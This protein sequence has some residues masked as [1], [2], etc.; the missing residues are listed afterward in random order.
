MFTLAVIAALERDFMVTP[1]IPGYTL[2]RKIAEG[3]SAEIYKALR[4][5]YGEECALKILHAR[6]T[7][8]RAKVKAFEAEVDILSRLEHPNVVV[9]GRSVE[10]ASRPCLE[11]EL[12]DTQHLK[13]LMAASQREGELLPLERALPILEQLARALS[14]LHDQGWLHRDIKPENVLV[15]EDDHVKL[16]DFS[17]ALPLHRSFWSRLFG[18]TELSEGTP[19]YL[20][21]EQI[22]REP[23]D[24]RS[25]IYS[26]GVLAYEMITGRPPIQAHSTKALFKAHLNDRPLPL[27]SSRSQVPQG[28]SRLIDACLSKERTA[29]PVSME[30]LATAMKIAASE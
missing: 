19:T 10:N 22:L 17:I 26:Y 5:P 11:L 2:V 7:K 29:R 1:K 25:D 27:R 6:L 4:Q 16:I 23:L 15:N 30:L 24:L 8:N 9:F 14:Y 20:S 12:Y 3:G 21:P 13:K 18:R 28:V